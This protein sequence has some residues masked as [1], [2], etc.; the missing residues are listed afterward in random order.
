MD[1]RRK[2]N[3]ESKTRGRPRKS[4]AAAKEESPTAVGP[5]TRARSKSPARV[6]KPKGRLTKKVT[7]SDSSQS[8]TP[9][10]TSPK[11]KLSPVKVTKANSKLLNDVSP[12]KRNV[13]MDDSGDSEIKAITNKSRLESLRSRITPANGKKSLSELTPT[14]SESSR[15]SASALSASVSTKEFSDGEDDESE[16]QRCKT[17]DNL[18]EFGGIWGSILL[19][20]ALETV[21]ITLSY[22]FNGK[23]SWSLASK[24]FKTPE[25]YCGA[26]SGWLFLEII[27]GSWIFSIIPIGKKVT[28]QSETGSITYNFTGLISAFLTVVSIFT[29]KYFGL[30]L[31]GGLYEVD[32]LL[33]LSVFYALGLSV[34]CYLKAKYWSVGQLNPFGKSKRL[35]VDFFAGVE[36]NPKAFN[37]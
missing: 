32:Q 12:K 17:P 15:R 16:I 28:L 23:S 14:P 21:P 18:L 22:V 9:K 3:V 26:V 29:L 5:T 6:V 36:V 7:E 19:L 31:L 1:T 27:A 25:T 24:H 4:P 8:S 20:L 11:I 37:R 34:V 33:H 30:N 35:L 2:R 13:F 10:Q